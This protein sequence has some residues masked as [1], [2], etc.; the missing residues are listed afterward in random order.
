MALALNGL[1]NGAVDQRMYATAQ[2]CYEESLAIR[3]EIGDR[4]GIAGC[5]NNLGWSAH[6][7]NNYADARQRYEE[8]LEI[9]RAI[10]DRRGTTIALNNLGFTAYALHDLPAATLYFDE[11]L[12]IAVEIGAVPLALEVLVGIARLRAS[13]GHPK[14]AAE[15][16]GLALHHPASNNDVKT[17][18]DLF[19]AE[20]ASLLP[21][22]Q[23]SAALERG[24]AQALDP[25]LAALVR[26]AGD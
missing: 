24:G 21:P 1:G 6:L 7:Q 11:A 15:L 12:R 16:L 23:L 25:V 9:S 22:E 18:I 8:S 14:F 20:L 3:R 13:A 19:L 10:G 2:Y 4:W 17:Q 5:L 26:E